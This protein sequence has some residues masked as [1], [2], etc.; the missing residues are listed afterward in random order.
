MSFELRRLDTGALVHRYATEGAA[1]SF[2][3][4]VIRVAGREEAACFVLEER[5]PLGG[6]RF[7]ADRAALVQR[8]LEDRAE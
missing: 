2:V 7:I 3:R 6:A 1:L 8:A 4:D 5:E